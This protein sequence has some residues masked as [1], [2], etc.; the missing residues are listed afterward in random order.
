[1]YSIIQNTHTHIYIYMHIQTRSQRMLPSRHLCQEVEARPV[2]AW[3][4]GMR[5]T[6]GSGSADSAFSSVE[7]LDDTFSDPRHELTEIWYCLWSQWG[8]RLWFC[9]WYHVQHAV[10]LSHCLEAI[11]HHLGPLKLNYAYVP[12]VTG[13]IAKESAPDCS[14]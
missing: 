13:Y 8:L 9:V 14:I 5:T 10:P 11:Q 6:S 4:I 12:I 7:I 1:M 2:D 3:Q